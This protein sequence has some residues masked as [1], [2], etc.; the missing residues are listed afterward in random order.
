MA[1]EWDDFQ[2]SFKKIQ[3]STKSLKPSEGEKL[4]KQLIADLN[5]AWDEE[6]LVRKAIK[7]AQ[8]NGAKA[9]KLSSLLKD[10]D[11]STAYKSWVK[12]TTAH[13]DRVK[14]LKNYSD[15]AMKHCEDL[16][17]QYGAVAKSVK[18]SKEPEAAKKNIKSAM[19]DAQHHMKMLEQ[20]NAIY[21]TL[22]LP[23]LFYAS[24]E[25]KTMEVIIKKEAEK[26]APAALPKILEDSGRKKGAKD[27][28]ALHR[29]AM[30][31]FEEAIKDSKINVEFA[32]TDMDKGDAMLASLSKLNNDFQNA[33]KKQFKEIDK[34][35]NKK[36]IEDT[37]KSI[38]AF[39]LEVEK[40]KKKATAAVKAAEKG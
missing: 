21:G 5:K 25:E 19:S 33:Q 31:A 37:I 16:K 29:S 14:A 40:V 34:S 11:F 38:N 18:Q 35:P 20:I 4:K 9:D 1:K 23:E 28:K 27:A 30:N 7:K 10:Q 8:Q 12:A 17:K 15:S 6:T 22:K 36:D 3:Q 24:K 13:K 2:K 32:R 39:K 26:N